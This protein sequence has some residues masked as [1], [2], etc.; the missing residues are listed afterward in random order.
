MEKFKKEIQGLINEV[1][2]LCNDRL[3]SV[4]LFGSCA[5]DICDETSDINLIIVIKDLEAIDLK[6][7]TKMVQ[8][9]EKTKNPM[10]IFMDYNEW[11]C[12]SDVYTI[13]YLDIKD[14]YKILFGEDVV[15]PLVI[16]TKNLRLQ[17]ESEIKNLLMKLRQNYILT[18]NNHKAKENLIKY[19]FKSSIS[20]FRA[21]LRIT[22]LGISDDKK[23]IIKR[24][25]DKTEIDLPTYEKC[26]SF[27]DN[28]NAIKAKE[29]DDI[30][31]KMITSTANVLK[32]VDSIE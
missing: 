2:S 7:A 6:N 17:C 32:Y 10:P 23:E 26:I 18:G 21:I 28:K 12:S 22:D 3:K 30:I 16:E 31:A 19:S 27:K 1:H 8:K 15:N 9:W 4:I 13:E 5:K 20:L 14:N 29:F 24:I 11:F 25:S